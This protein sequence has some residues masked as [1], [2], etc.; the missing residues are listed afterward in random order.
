MELLRVAAQSRDHSHPILTAAPSRTQLCQA[1]DG[2]HLSL[3][4]PGQALFP[5]EEALQ[6][7]KYPNKGLG[8]FCTNP[9][10]QQQP[11]RQQHGMALPALP[12]SC[13]SPPPRCAGTRWAQGEAS[14]LIFCMS[15]D[16][17][18]DAS[19]RKC[20][21]VSVRSSRPCRHQYWA[22][23]AAPFPPAHGL[24]PISILLTL[25]HKD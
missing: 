8:G 3:S 12:P 21:Q 23:R 13:S 20:P 18:I 5:W 25:S 6:L 7:C 19:C 16:C 10:E 11:G 17:G 9:C 1:L 14:S 22:G 2:L 24:L 4:H 15:Q